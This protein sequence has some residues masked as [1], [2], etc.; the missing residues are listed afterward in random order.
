MKTTMMVIASGCAIT[1]VQPAFADGISLSKGIKACKAEL[2][3]HTPALKRYTVD[4]EESRASDTQ[5]W[6]AFNVLDETGRMAKFVCT[7]DRVTRIA[8]VERKKPKM[9]DYMLAAPRQ[10][11]IKVA[12]TEQTGGA[13]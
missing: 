4:Y 12:E 7:V 8:A 2:A 9:S 1:L 3:Q 13:Q 11:A 6:I 10:P 5:M